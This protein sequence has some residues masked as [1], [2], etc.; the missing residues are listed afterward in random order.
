MN[1]SNKKEL[2]QKSIEL[3][4]NNIGRLFQRA[5]RLYSERALSL[6]HEQGYSDV[7]LSHSALFAN[8]DLE[9][10]QI[11]T[12]ADRAGMTKQAMGQLATDLETKGYIRKIK[13]PTDK[14]AFIVQFTDQGKKALHAAYDIKLKVEKEFQQVVGTKNLKALQDVLQ[15][16]LRGYQ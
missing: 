16:L 1:Q 3:R 4:E 11:T 15:N 14:R 2:A 10:T 5:G 13:D 12:I 7:K 6:L 9:G 8:L